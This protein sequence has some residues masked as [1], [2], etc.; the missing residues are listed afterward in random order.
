MLC[1]HCLERLWACIMWSWNSRQRVF[2]LFLSL[3]LCHSPPPQDVIG[4]MLQKL[5]APGSKDTLTQ[6]VG[7]IYPLHLQKSKHSHWLFYLNDQVKL[8]FVIFIFPQLLFASSQTHIS[9]KSEQNYKISGIWLNPAFL[10][11]WVTVSC[12]SWVLM[13]Y[14]L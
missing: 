7:G 14:F 6:P 8:F 12:S 11:N 13:Y 5:A 1:W 9:F 4:K 10:W 3:F 2:S